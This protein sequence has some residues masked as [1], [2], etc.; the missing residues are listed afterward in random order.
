MNRRHFLQ[1]SALPAFGTLLPSAFA[2]VLPAADLTL[3]SRPVRILLRS[4]WQMV[5]IGD[6]AHTPGVLAILE[7]FLPNAEI[8]L[9]AGNE[10][11]DEVHQMEAKRFPQLKKV[12][13]GSVSPDGKRCNSPELAQALEECDFILHGSGASFVAYRDVLGAVARTG[14]SYGIFGITW[15]GADEKQIQFLSTAKFVFFRDSVSLGVAKEAGVC[16]PIMEFGPD[17]A[18]ACDL[19]NDQAAEQFLKEHDLAEGQF[20][21]VIPRYRVTPY[22]KIR[23]KEMTEK[24]RTNWELSQQM[25]EHDHLPIRQAI[26]ETVRQ[27]DLKVLICPEDVSQVA[28]GREVLYEPLPEDVK[29][30][31]VW[32]DRFWLTDEAIST[33]V[34][35]AG[36][37]GL[38][39]HSP[40]MCVGNGIPAIVGRFHQQ[41]SKGLMW[42]D[43]GLGDWLFNLDEEAEIPGIVPAVLKMLA[44]R[45]LSRQKVAAA[46]KFVAERQKRM[47]EAL[48]AELG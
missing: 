26:I 44:N 11:S 48:N 45:E 35:S 33:Y 47:G 42:R 1:T 31:V 13:K 21:C 27:T 8:T 39:M 7:R 28:L 20:A 37:F 25:K 6:I 46:Q 34:R 32:R 24:D 18:F 3:R 10:Y 23:G 43:I 17:G 15:S 38:E 4:S 40:I 36:L 41:T 16:A 9:W 22:W 14:K 12:V 2:S 29:R 19:R 5:N 30:R